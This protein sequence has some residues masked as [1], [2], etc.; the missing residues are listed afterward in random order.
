MAVSDE[1][2]SNVNELAVQV[3]RHQNTI[4]STRTELQDGRCTGVKREARDAVKDSM[5]GET[6]WSNSEGFLWKDNDGYLA[7]AEFLEVRK[8]GTLKRSHMYSI[9][10]YLRVEIMKSRRQIQKLQNLT[11][12]LQQH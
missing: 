11:T 9:R 10:D 8:D 7:A 6:T 1:P 3:W 12:A 2:C 5:P 4:L